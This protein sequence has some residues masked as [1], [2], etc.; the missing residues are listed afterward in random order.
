MKPIIMLKGGLGN[1]LFQWTYAHSLQ[2]HQKFYPSRFHYGHHDK[3]KYLELGD[4][5]ESCPHVLKG[6]SLS[7]SREY[8]SHLGEWMWNKKLS[9]KV[10]EIFLGYCQEDPRI[11]QRQSGNR[12]RKSW[13]SSGY[14][15]KNI[16]V[17]NSAGA[18]EFEILPHTE[19]IASG[20]IEAK[21]IPQKY[22]ILHIRTGDYS[23]QSA[24]NINFIGNLH[25]RYFLD[26]L[27]KLNANYLI[28]LTE[29]ADHIPELLNKIKPDL[30]LDT[31][32][33]NA[34]ET[35]AT[36]TFSESMIGAN[37][38]LSWWGAKLASLKGANTWLPEN[39]S[40]W[41]NITSINYKFQNLSLLES[42]WRSM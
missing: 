42:T 30:V 40:I 36:M 24:K 2:P 29:N 15:Q 34:W 8:L 18:V 37:S 7:P 14:F 13:I 21:V 33:V 6:G 35:L 39:W 19:K 27:D 38:S 25:D 12:N 22:S 28:V 26:N 23:R 3:I 9:R 41:N 31:G 4:I 1:Q 32:Q 17:D 5:I 20:L 16:Y 11:D 10:A